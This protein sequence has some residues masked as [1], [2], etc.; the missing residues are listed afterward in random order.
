MYYITL[1][2]NVE[3]F[4]QKNNN[5]DIEICEEC[6]C[7]I[8]CIR[9]NIYILTKDEKEKL[10]C[11]SCFE[12]LWKEYFNNGWNGDDIKYYL[13]LENDEKTGENR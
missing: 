11:Q 10:W 13:E 1:Y 9:N 4:T 6:N 8:N 5:I 12:E 3:E 7:E 2:M